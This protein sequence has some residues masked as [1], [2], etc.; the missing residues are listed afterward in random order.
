MQKVGNLGT[1]FSDI[2]GR[3]F[4]H[5]LEIKAFKVYIFFLFLFFLQIKSALTPTPQGTVN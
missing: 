2:F 3:N 1:W 4:G 5:F